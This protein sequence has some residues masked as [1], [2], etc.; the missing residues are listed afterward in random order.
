V[1]FAYTINT[2]KKQLI[3][4]LIFT[5]FIRFPVWT[6]CIYYYY[7]GKHHTIS[8][9]DIFNYICTLCIMLMDYLWSRQNYKKLERIWN[10]E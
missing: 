3:Y 2:V 8:A 4:R 6:M 5:C 7:I 9:L 10:E 1:T